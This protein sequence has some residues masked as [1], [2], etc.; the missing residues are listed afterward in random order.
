MK[1]TEDVDKIVVPSD[2]DALKRSFLRFFPIP[3]QKKRTE[4]E[5]H[6]KA[7]V[8]IEDRYAILDL[9]LKTAISQNAIRVQI[10]DDVNSYLTHFAGTREGE[11]LSYLD[12]TR[13][14]LLEPLS[15]PVGNIRIREGKLIRL[16]FFTELFFAECY[17][18]F[19]ATYANRCIQT[20]FP[21]QLL[22]GPQK[23]AS[24]RVK[25]TTPELLLT[26]VTR[27]SG[28]GFDV[29][30][31]DIGTGG[32]CFLG[33][34]IHGEIP[35][36]STI[37]ITLNPNKG[38]ILYLKAIVLPAVGTVGKGVQRA[39]FIELDPHTQYHLARLVV[40]IHKTNLRNRHRIFGM[41]GNSDGEE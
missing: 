35:V 26:E 25:V 7:I 41:N 18:D 23:R 40:R 36:G 19:I 4:A 22:Q 30:I 16:N 29:N 37:S 15:P 28:L 13:Y 17:V 31:V 34:E 14:L 38:A 27:P 32:I 21:I 5:K 10:G 3:S 1:T 11:D 33:K 6:K 20:T 8:V 12:V 2:L 24:V 39:K 9:I